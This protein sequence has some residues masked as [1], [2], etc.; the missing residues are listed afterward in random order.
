MTA[1]V[2]TPATKRPTCTVSQVVRGR[3]CV[4]SIEMVKCEMSAPKSTPTES[5]RLNRADVV[6]VFDADTGE[7]LVT[8]DD[9]GNGLLSRLL[10][11]ANV[12]LRLAVAVS[13]FP[14]LEFVGLGE[15]SG[16]YSLYVN[17][18]RGSLVSIGDD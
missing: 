18:Y 8:D 4:T 11:Q 14:D 12:D 1:G 9:G 3:S 5:P 16:R 15:E 2:K 7:L 6:G 13:T 10:L 17:T